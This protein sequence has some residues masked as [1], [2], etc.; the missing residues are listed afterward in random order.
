MEWLYVKPNK[1]TALIAPPPKQKTR[2]TQTDH[3]ILHNKETQYELISVDDNNNKDNEY[4]D[5]RKLLM[6]AYGLVGISTVV[7]QLKAAPVF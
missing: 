4:I 3:C 7:K 6:L 5:L 1:K 2:A